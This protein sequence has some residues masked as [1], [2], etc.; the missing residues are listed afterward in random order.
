[1]NRRRFLVTDGPNAHIHCC[2]CRKATRMTP[3]PNGEI[4]RTETTYY[5]QSHI[6]GP[7]SEPWDVE[8]EGKAS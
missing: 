8:Q 2:A 1:M 6:C 5:K 4:T 7:V 3:A